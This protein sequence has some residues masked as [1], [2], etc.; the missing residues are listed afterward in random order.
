MLYLLTSASE[1]TY[2]LAGLLTIVTV[3]AV[4]HLKEKKH[5]PERA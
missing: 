1:P 3:T 2:L 5:D 4:I